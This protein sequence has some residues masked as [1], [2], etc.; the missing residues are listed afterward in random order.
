M[1][2]NLSEDLIKQAVDKTKEK[3]DFIL[4]DWKGLG[5]EKQRITEMLKNLEVKRT[6]QVLKG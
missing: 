6:D 2:E 5:K 4:L 1:L 3:V